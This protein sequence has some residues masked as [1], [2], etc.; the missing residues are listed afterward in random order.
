MSIPRLIPGIPYGPPPRVA[1]VSGALAVP[2][3]IVIH[4]TSNTAT[5]RAEAS[6]AATRTDAQSLWTSCHAYVDTAGPL[7][8]TPL[9]TLAWA[10]YSFANHHGWHIEMCG[11]NAGQA[12]AVPAVTIEH[13][14]RLVAQLCAL[15]GIEVAHLGPAE[16]AAIAAGTSR[17]TGVCGHYDITVGLGVG[18]HD[19]PGPAFD[20]QAFI[21]AVQQGGDVGIS[22]TDAAYL[23]WRVE[24]LAHMF[25]KVRSGPEQG[26]DMQ[27]VQ[28]LLRI[29]ANLVAD[30]A[31]DRAA[32]AAL[33]TI[34]DLINAGGGDL[35]T[36]SVLAAIADVRA[37]ESATVTALRNQLADLNRR[38]TA[39]A[40]AQSAALAE[41]A[42]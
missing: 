36:A 38:L 37:A 15:A 20:W 35:D 5:A 25:A 39:A 8:S 6:Y 21:A 2:P 33:K 13:T 29:D 34:G 27:I 7:G 17:R 40:Q 14:A 4:D 18:D 22:D 31:E 19:D 41:G 3:L 23:T 16:V 12:G 24:A 28:T 32:T 9:D 10:A 42:G 30:L 26:A 1:S 11:M